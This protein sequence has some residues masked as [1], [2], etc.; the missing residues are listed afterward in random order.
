LVYDKLNKVSF[1]ASRKDLS[2]S[3]LI[4]LTG[5]DASS[6]VSVLSQID[7]VVNKVCTAAGISYFFIFNFG[8]S[9]A[10]L[11]CLIAVF[12]YIKKQIDDQNRSI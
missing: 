4:K 8:W 7:S 3:E 12:K 2:E 11:L 9:F 5:S 1:A 10:V 6:V